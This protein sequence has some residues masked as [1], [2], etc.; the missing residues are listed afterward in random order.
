MKI[1]I[2]GPAASGKSTTAQ[3][4]AQRLGYR[5]I[6]SGAMYRVVT[7]KALEEGIPT[8]DARRVADIARRTEIQFVPGPDG[9]QRIFMDGRDVTDR[10]RTHEVNR[11]INPVAA[12]PEVREIL[13]KK[14]QALGQEGG[15]V[16]DG[17]DIG[18]VVFPDAELKIYMDASAE[19]RARRR[20]KELHN[21]GIEVEYQEVYQEILERDRSDTSRSVGPLKRAPDAVVID[22]TRLSVDEQVETIYRLAREIIEKQD[23]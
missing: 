7:L 1:A 11:H 17:R 10:I 13:V 12:N 22:T 8:T 16:M 15:V 3:R 21:R 5:Y 4:V 18:T 20:V 9:S 14:Q 23:C 19:E 6:D 2:D